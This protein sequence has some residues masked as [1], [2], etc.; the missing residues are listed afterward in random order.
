M[1][2]RVEHACLGINSKRDNRICLLIGGEEEGAFRVQPEIA[3]RF[4]LRRFITDRGEPSGRL[5]NCADGDAI[6]PTV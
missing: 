5:I 6:V 1:S 3:R 2:R 4:P